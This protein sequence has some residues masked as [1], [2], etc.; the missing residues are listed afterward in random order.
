MGKVF[1]GQT[2]LTIKLDTGSLLTNVDVAKIKYKKG[3]NT[4]GEFVA[5]VSGRHR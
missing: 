3:D 2:K 4:L 5:A 1:V